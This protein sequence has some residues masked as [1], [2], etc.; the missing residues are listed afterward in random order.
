MKYYGIEIKRFCGVD[1]ST[2]TPSI[3]PEFI[4]RMAESVKSMFAVVE[5][6]DVESF[7]CVM[8]KTSN[9]IFQAV[10]EAVDTETFTANI[11]GSREYS[12]LVEMDKYELN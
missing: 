7:V 9:D 10:F 5:A 4:V 8:N 12:P 2:N 6:S 3:L 1:I 11:T